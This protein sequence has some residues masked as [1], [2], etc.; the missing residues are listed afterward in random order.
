MSP[1]VFQ[2]E[3]D[4]A[5]Q[6]ISLLSQQKELLR[7]R[8]DAMSDYPNLKREKTELQGQL[9]LLKKQLEEAQEET[10][11]LHA[12]E[13]CLLFPSTSKETWNVAA[14]SIKFPMRQ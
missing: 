3:L 5:Q 12:G 10:Q 8:L 1:P 13:D 11:L 14:F 2:V 4:T 6:Q 7:E 9:R